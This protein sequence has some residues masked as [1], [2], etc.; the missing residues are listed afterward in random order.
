M[1]GF[2]VSPPICE[3]WVIWL[4]FEV[5]LPICWCLVIWLGFEVCRKSDMGL[6]CYSSRVSFILAS[7]NT[8]MGVMGLELE[9]LAWVS[10]LGSLCSLP[11]NLDQ[12]LPPLS[13]SRIGFLGSIKARLPST[14]TNQA[15]QTHITCNAILTGTDLR[16]GSKSLC[17]KVGLL[18]HCF[19]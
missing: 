18:F 7:F 2:E 10:T 16:V 11:S 1:W 4:R 17:C 6:W 13:L 5:F 8:V 3:C 9:L 12:I 19:T 14:S 15:K